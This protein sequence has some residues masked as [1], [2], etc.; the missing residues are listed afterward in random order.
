MKLSLYVFTCFYSLFFWFQIFPPFHK[1][2]FGKLPARA[3]GVFQQGCQDGYINSDVCSASPLE[4]HEA[5][6]GEE[7]QVP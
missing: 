2:E 7:S 5:A 1:Q 3:T 4:W 6:V